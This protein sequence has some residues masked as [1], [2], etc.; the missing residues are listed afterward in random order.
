MKGPVLY[1][2][3]HLIRSRNQGSGWTPYFVLFL[4]AFSKPLSFDNPLSYFLPD[5][6]RSS[7]LVFWEWNGVHSLVDTVIDYACRW[8]RMCTFGVRLLPLVLVSVGTDAEETYSATELERFR[9][10]GASLN[11]TVCDMWEE[12][13]CQEFQH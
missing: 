1:S 3:G 6:N 13:G 7:Y 4:T 9:S 8:S 2:T 10:N 12:C 11:C 5:R